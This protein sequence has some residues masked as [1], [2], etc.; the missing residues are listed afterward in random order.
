MSAGSLLYH[1][2]GRWC[3]QC[4]I[5]VLAL[6]VMGTH[7]HLLATR[8]ATPTEIATALGISERHV[9]KV[10]AG[11]RDEATQESNLPTDGLRRPARFEDAIRHQTG[12][13]PA[14]G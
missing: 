4:E 3:R 7:Y 1:D 9:Q 14:R 10:L 11:Q 6:C 13:A 2:I 5:Q 12:A 8:G